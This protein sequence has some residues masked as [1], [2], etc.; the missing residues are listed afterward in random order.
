MG[1][2]LLIPLVIG[3]F[4]SWF[5]GKSL[6][7][8]GWIAPD[9][10]WRKTGR[11]RSD[12]M[13]VNG[14]SQKAD[15]ESHLNCLTKKLQT[16]LGEHYGSEGA[17]LHEHLNS[18]EEKIDAGVV[19]TLHKLASVRNQANHDA[20][21]DDQVFDMNEYQAMAEDAQLKMLKSLGLDPLA[22]SIF[23][24]WKVP[25][26]IFYILGSVLAAVALVV[27]KVF[28]IAVPVIRTMVVLYFRIMD[29]FFSPLMVFCKKPK[30]R[31]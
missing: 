3:P 22:D 5:L 16:F 6:L 2:V 12:L 31:S 10:A 11:I 14:C 30:N 4:I 9:F 8:T 15:V 1:E 21:F 25:H 18:V 17:G 20:L 29:R 19:R 7:E 27:S 26:Y 24:H 28:S 13:N 23:S